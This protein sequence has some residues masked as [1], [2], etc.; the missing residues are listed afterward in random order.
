MAHFVVPNGQHSINSDGTTFMWSTTDGAIGTIV[1]YKFQVGKR[2]NRYDIYDG[3]WL[4][5]GPPG[6]YTDNV[7]NLP[8]A[9]T[10]SVRAL[11]KKNDGQTRRTAPQSFGCKP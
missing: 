9:G 2:A 3:P 10:L 4:P 5:G 8:G 11:Y 1:E 6:V 7:K